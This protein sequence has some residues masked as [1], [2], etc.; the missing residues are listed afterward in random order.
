MAWSSNR[1]RD[2]GQDRLGSWLVVPMLR[3]RSGPYAA[4]IAWLHNQTV[5]VQGADDD[6]RV[7]RQIAFSVRFDF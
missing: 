5:Y 1:I 3:F 4:G 2:A 6:T 7:G